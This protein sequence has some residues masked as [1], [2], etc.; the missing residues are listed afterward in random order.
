MRYIKLFFI[1]VVVFSIILFCL[2]LLFPS[3]TYVSRAVN[4]S[5]SKENKHYL[6]PQIYQVAF[7]DNSDVNIFRSQP[8]TLLLASPFSSDIKQGVAIY[9]AGNDSNTVQVFYKIYV[10]FYK[11]WKKFALMLNETKYGPSLDSAISR[12]GRMF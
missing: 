3:T 4:V 11:P 10:P 6:L 2:S 8:D 9:T 7:Q 12:I 1:S 5:Q